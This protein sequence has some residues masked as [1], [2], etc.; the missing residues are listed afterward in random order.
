MYH[1]LFI[2]AFLIGFHIYN[3]FYPPRNRVIAFS[4]S[5]LNIMVPK[6]FLYI[7]LIFS[8]ALVFVLFQKF[9]GVS[10]YF[11][12]SRY[13][14]YK[15]K[16]DRNLGVYGVGFDFFRNVLILIYAKI[17][18]I[19][20][21]YDSKYGRKLMPVFYILLLFYIGSVI[22][23]G[24]RRPIVGMILALLF[25]KAFLG[26][27]NE[28]VLF[29]AGIP[30]VFLVHILSYLRHLINDPIKMFQFLKSNYKADWFDVSKGELGTPYLILNNLISNPLKW[31]YFYGYTYIS[32]FSLLFPKV[33]LPIRSE[34]IANWFVEVFYPDIF[35]KGGGWGFS[36]VAEG[37]I[38]FGVLGILLNGVLLGLLAN[39]LW[40]KLCIFNP[41][42]IKITLYGLLLSIFFV[43]GRTDTGGLMK[44]Y[45]VGSL[46][47]IL[48]MLV[49]FKIVKANS[50]EM[51]RKVER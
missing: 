15:M 28:R 17:L 3:Y 27:L 50:V 22:G 1:T 30:G 14:L 23:V 11:E 32:N 47:P 34:G 18:F 5:S 6:V 35:K 46:L 4:E 44:E 9:G 40:N 48:G 7:S 38:N 39:L 43:F 24:D 16:R 33:I 13:D 45:F 25:V 49:L 12:T 42:P 8:V 21:Y 41:N 2:I 29:V 31:D 19:R 51:K 20:K 37:Y 36:V 26:R 10:N